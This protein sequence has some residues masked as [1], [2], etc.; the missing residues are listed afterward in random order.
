MIVIMQ[1]TQEKANLQK[2]KVNATKARRFCVH[3]NK[4]YTGNHML[5][6]RLIVMVWQADR[7]A[8]R[9][10]GRILAVHNFFKIPQLQ[11]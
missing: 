7:L 5:R 4:L 8:G 9:Q 6:G 10:A 11:F 1:N 3:G 2:T